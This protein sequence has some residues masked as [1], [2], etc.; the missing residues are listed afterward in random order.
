MRKTYI[1]PVGLGELDG[2]GSPLY[3]GAI[4]EDMDFASH[5][6]ERE[7]EDAFYGLEICEVAL[8]G[9][10]GAACCSDGVEGVIAGGSGASDET[11]VCAG[12]C[13]GDGTRSTD[14]CWR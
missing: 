7:L 5:G 12:L 11:D 10:D 4:D 14:A 1:I 8:Y 13:E 6:V 3:S 9:F 2:R